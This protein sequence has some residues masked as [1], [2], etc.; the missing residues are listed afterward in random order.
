MVHLKLAGENLVHHP[1]ERR[2]SLSS[3]TTF[4]VTAAGFVETDYVE[5]RDVSAAVDGGA[6]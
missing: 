3:V 5:Q 1:L 2:C 6:V 4:E